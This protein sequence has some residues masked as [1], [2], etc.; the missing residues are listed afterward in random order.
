M[1]SHVVPILL[2]IALPYGPSGI[3]ECTPM[4]SVTSFGV[5]SH[6]VLIT[7]KNAL[8]SG[9]PIQGWNWGDVKS[10][11]RVSYHMVSQNWVFQKW[12]FENLLC[13][14]PGIVFVCFEFVKW[15][16]FGGHHCPGIP[17]FDRKKLESSDRTEPR[18]RKISEWTR[19][20]KNLENLGPD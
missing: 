7:F 12:E 10:R 17:F 20:K 16:E 15:P 5:H 1:H 2:R 9:P 11:L 14:Q 19:T 18:P 13:M 3:L 6:L 8:R 4:L